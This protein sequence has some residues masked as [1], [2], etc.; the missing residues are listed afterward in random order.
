MEEGRRLYRETLGTP[1][2]MHVNPSYHGTADDGSSR[3]RPVQCSTV[4]T[5]TCV[6][7][8]TVERQRV[9]NLRRQEPALTYSGEAEALKTL[10]DNG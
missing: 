5:T 8:T 6:T 7:D 4:C 3:Y 1:H 2:Q 9:R 10:L